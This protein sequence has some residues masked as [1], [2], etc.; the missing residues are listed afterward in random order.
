MRTAVL[1][2]IA[3]VALGSSAA[4]GQQL[5]VAHS[6]EQLQVQAGRHGYGH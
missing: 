2:T 3:V 5:E 4:T 6:F 1:A